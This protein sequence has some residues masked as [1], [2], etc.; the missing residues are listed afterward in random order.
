MRYRK[1]HPDKAVRLGVLS[2]KEP[3]AVF[4]AD[5]KRPDEEASPNYYACPLVVS[6]TLDMGC[7]CR[8]H[9]RRHI[10]PRPPLRPRRRN[11]KPSSTTAFQAPSH[12]NLWQLRPKAN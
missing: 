9:M 3:L 8:A 6:Q 4:R 12:S 2:K 5:C 1:P 11:V 7:N 10:P